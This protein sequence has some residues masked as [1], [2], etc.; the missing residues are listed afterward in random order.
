MTVWTPTEAAT[1]PPVNLEV[2]NDAKRLKWLKTSVAPM[3]ERMKA[4][5]SIRELRTA[6]G[7]Q[8]DTPWIAEV[9]RLKA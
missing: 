7:L 4:R 9:P 1:L 3:L 8:Y 5:Y 6:L 2:S